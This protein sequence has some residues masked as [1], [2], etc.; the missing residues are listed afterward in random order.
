MMNQTGETPLTHSPPTPHHRPSAAGRG[1]TD[2]RAPHLSLSSLIKLVQFLSLTFNADAPP[3]FPHPT[4][5]C[6]PFYAHAHAMGSGLS[7]PKDRRP[8]VVRYEED[9]AKALVDEFIASNPELAQKVVAYAHSQL[10]K[11]GL[12]SSGATGGA[13]ALSASRP[14]LSRSLV[15]VNQRKSFS[16]R[17][18]SRLTS[19]DA[20]A[21]SLGVSI[22][23][24]STKQ[25]ISLLSA[26]AA[27]YAVGV[28]SEAEGIKRKWLDLLPGKTEWLQH[29]PSGADASWWKGKERVL[30]KHAG[31]W[32]L[33]ERKGEQKGGRDRHRDR[34]M[35]ESN[36]SRKHDAEL[37]SV[38]SSLPRSLPPSLPPSSLYLASNLIDLFL[39]THV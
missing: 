4:P 18:A 16:E 36:S 3:Q 39:S 6:S 25:E 8:S 27:Q 19:S 7:S 13:K 11:R 30:R 23:D 20:D 33:R 17:V 35:K 1:Y 5:L 28:N 22:F 2:I 31:R 14:E 37:P 12:A 32:V 24:E 26:K 15:A 9:Q 38:P 29:V 10:A 21:K 34:E